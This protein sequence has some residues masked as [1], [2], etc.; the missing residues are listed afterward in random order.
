V[1]DLSAVNRDSITATITRTFRRFEIEVLAR[2]E[3]TVRSGRETPTH[4]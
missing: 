3:G 4:N 2:M 1:V